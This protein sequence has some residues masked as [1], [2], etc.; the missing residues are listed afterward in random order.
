MRRSEEENNAKEGA[1][2]KKLSKAIDLINKLKGEYVKKPDLK[3]LT[4]AD[5]EEIY[6]N[7]S[8]NWSKNK[9]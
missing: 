1:N 4:N 7:E 2:I 3:K 5:I 8:E 9:I 6:Y